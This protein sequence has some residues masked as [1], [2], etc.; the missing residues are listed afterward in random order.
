M[1]N[2]WYTMSVE[3]VEKIHQT[4]IKNG[5]TSKEATDR[6]KKNGLNNVYSMSGGG[7]DFY[8][9]HAF[10]NL[11]GL[12]LIVV[13]G[14]HAVIKR[15]FY[16]LIPIVVLGISMALVY[17]V[18]VRS[19]MVLEQ[20]G[21]RSLPMTKVMRDGRLYYVR[22]DRI[23]KGD[24]VFISAGDI[25]PGDA[26][27]FEDEELIVLEKGVCKSNTP[28]TKNSGFSSQKDLVPEEQNNMVFASTMVLKGRGKAVICE[29]GKN[30]HV[31][32]SGKVIPIYTCDNVKV[33]EKFKK[34][35]SIL[36]TAMI[37]FVFI[38]VMVS[39]FM[40]LKMG[41]YDSF[42]YSLS[43]AVSSLTECLPLFALII[44]SCGIFGAGKR[45]KNINSGVDIK[46]AEKIQTIKDVD[47]VIFHRESLFC[48]GDISLDLVYADNR[49]KP[50][51]A[52]DSSVVR[53]ITYGVIA[54]GLYGGAISVK[55]LEKS[56]ISYT[57]EEETIIKCAKQFGVYDKRLDDKYPAV[58]SGER[59][60]RGKTYHCT[61]V[62]C[63]QRYDMYSAC[64]YDA[65]IS[66][67]TCE[68]IGGEMVPLSRERKI[69]I[70]AIAKERIKENCLVLAIIY[71]KG[72]RNDYIRPAE[73]FS[74]NVFC[75]FIFIE[76]PMQKGGAQ[77]VSECKRAGMKLVMLCDDINPADVVFAHSA[78]IINSNDECVDIKTLS[79]MDDDLIR[80]NVPMYNMYQ[81]LNSPQRRYVIERLKQDCGYTVAYL[82]R[83][84]SHI[85][86][87]S[88]A[89][90]GFAELITVSERAAQ[91]GISLNNSDI[92]LSAVN[93]KE[94]SRGNC[95]A[96]KFISDA[97]VSK[98]GKDGTGGLN[99]AIMTVVAAKGIFKNLSSMCK[100]LTVT[101]VFRFILVAVSIFTG[102]VWLTPEQLVF[103]GVM[104]DIGAVILIA[105]EKH[106]LELLNCNNIKQTVSTKKRGLNVIWQYGVISVIWTVSSIAL[107]MLCIS[108]GI[109]TQSRITSILFIS[110][111]ISQFVLL[112]EISREDSIFKGKFRMYT[113]Y[114]VYFLTIALFYGTCLMFPGIGEYVG[115]NLI[116]HEEWAVALISPASLLVLI[117]L[118]RV[119]LKLIYRIKNKKKK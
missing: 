12:L 39:V 81:G 33:L 94:T 78:G 75:G 56:T 83:E 117:E 61:T 26:R 64:S 68:Y 29:T 53:M 37:A 30:T 22:Q 103:M 31:C 113:I 9:F 97:T 10:A 40:N 89:D 32:S 41:I 6:L 100:Y 73:N 7:T 50:V 114:P 38:V 13:C 2:R 99:S 21:R 18:N 11:L 58:F 45:R 93:S 110:Y 90:T 35:S 3:D 67:C 115:I 118:Y 101:F 95:E 63:G 84:L 16:S 5:L 25:V 70:S 116:Y 49:I 44:I 104:C 59:I 24:I 119:I 19:K 112:A 1:K 23:V 65:A 72:V 20:M 36:S 98:P 69:E 82:G 102:N 80:T 108:F 91:K 27:L 28:V 92:P 42:Y 8:M 51:R 85:S 86:A 74:D 79:S 107:L 87:M 60:Y 109:I 106:D 43:L 15:D 88:S 55:K 47:C 17:F 76:R 46:N 57:R 77:F 96:L 48:E 71:K 66:V 14:V 105:F 34:T 54:S 52:D 111:I 62:R 4:D